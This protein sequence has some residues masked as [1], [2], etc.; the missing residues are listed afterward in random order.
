[1]PRSS[2][3]LPDLP[4]P[5]RDDLRSRPVPVPAA[6]RPA[7]RAGPRPGRHPDAD[8]PRDRRSD[9]ADGRLRPGPRR[10]ARAGGAPMIT[11]RTKIQLLVFVL[12]TLLGV[13]YV[14]AR[15]ARL[16]RVF[17]DDDL[18]RRRALRR[19]R[20]HLRRRRGHLPRRHGRRGVRDGQL[21]D[22]GVDVY[23]D[24]DKEQ[25]TIPADSRRRWS[26]TGPRSVSSTSSSSRR[27]TTGRYLEDGSEI[28][29]GP[30][31]AP[32]S[33]P[34]SCWRTSPT[35]SSRRRGRPAHGHRRVRARRSA[36]PGE[37]LGQIIDTGNSFIETANAN[38][39]ITTGLIRDSNTVLETQ[40]D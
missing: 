11:R 3:Q 26:A 12:I 10:P 27:P 32:R 5:D 37:D 24:I 8:R 22:E 21:T 40:V 23:L 13:T 33:R 1:M 35:P 39:D 2:T 18:H 29:A 38:F 14:G 6:R 34:T 28:A 4:L 30:T 7:H 17:F 19:L 16:D 9:R 36:A 20:R 25:D 31:P 15:Y